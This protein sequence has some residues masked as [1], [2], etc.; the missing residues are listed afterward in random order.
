MIDFSTYDF[1]KIKEEDKI[2]FQQG[3]I[4][5]EI[6]FMEKMSLWKRFWN[7]FYPPKMP[8]QYY[9]KASLKQIKEQKEQ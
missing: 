1:N 6:E 4:M 7:P 9:W 8:K 2:L 3:Q 5:N